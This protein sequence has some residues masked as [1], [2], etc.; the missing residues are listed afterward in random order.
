M[1]TKLGAN[2]SCEKE[3]VEV[4]KWLHIYFNDLKNYTQPFS[5]KTI[6]EEV[7]LIFC[8][9]EVNNVYLYPHMSKK[10]CYAQ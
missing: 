9:T 7:E 5:I 10:W 1:Y 3:K 8:E 6:R 4:Y 2:S